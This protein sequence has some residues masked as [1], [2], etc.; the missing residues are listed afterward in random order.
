MNKDQVKGRIK[1][2]TGKVKEVAGRVVGNHELERKGKIE[3][4]EGK[5]QAGYGDMK[6]DIKDAV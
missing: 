5:V 6:E 1:E 4:T 3:N 2:T